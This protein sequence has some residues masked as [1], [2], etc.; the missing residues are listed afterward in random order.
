MTGAN[1]GEAN[2]VHL[3]RAKAKVEGHRCH[4]HSSSLPLRGEG[5]GGGSDDE[6][7][8]PGWGVR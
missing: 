2:V 3:D 8:G 7:G 6:S 4:N 5:W 1:R